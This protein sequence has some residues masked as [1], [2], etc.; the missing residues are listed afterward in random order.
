MDSL[1]E[2]LVVRRSWSLKKRIGFVFGAVL[3]VVSAIYGSYFYG[4]QKGISDIEGA[5]LL[6]EDLRDNVKLLKAEGKA[7]NSELTRSNSESDVQKAAYKELEKAYEQLDKKNE[8]LNRRVNFY[9]SILSPEDGISGV[10]V[11]TVKLLEGANA[12]EVDFE[13]TLIQSVQHEKE[14][15]VAV[16]VQ[17]F[18]NRRSSEPISSWQSSQKDYSF[19]YSEI[20]KGSIKLGENA[21][22][23]VIKFTVV[24]E[25]DIEKQIVEWH[26]L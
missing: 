19:R 4:Y 2:K 12:N 21:L 26:K 14:A 13:L 6:I 22:E 10:R 5:S 24:P 17:L 3:I 9:R 16:E 20:V 8:F 23:G 1:N 25:G 7:F 15:K 11:H 18:A